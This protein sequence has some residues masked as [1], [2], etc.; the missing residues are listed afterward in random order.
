MRQTCACT[1]KIIAA[2]GLSGSRRGRLGMLVEEARDRVVAGDR[3]AGEP[4]DRATAGS[5]VAEG[6]PRGQQVRVLPCNSALNRPKAPAPWIA[7][8]S[9]RPARLRK[10]Y[11]RHAKSNG[12]DADTLARLPLA[13]PDGLTRSAALA[14]DTRNTFGPGRCAPRRLPGRSR[15]AA[16]PAPHSPAHSQT[17]PSKERDTASSGCPSP[18]QPVSCVDFR[19]WPGLHRGDLMGACSRRLLTWQR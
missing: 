9:L 18:H 14:E 19:P 11:R 15:P 17:P 10:F 16:A 5:G 6:V 7:N 8:A 4:L 3:V 2:N 12:I 1:A 13:D